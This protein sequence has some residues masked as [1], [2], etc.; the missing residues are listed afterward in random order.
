MH[1]NL[2]APS[3]LEL[4][5]HVMNVYLYITQTREGNRTGLNMGNTLTY[6]MCGLHADWT[7]VKGLVIHM[8][9]INI[10]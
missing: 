2:F 8:I 5:S 6:K 9:L 1:A 4:H 3:T 10:T 7:A